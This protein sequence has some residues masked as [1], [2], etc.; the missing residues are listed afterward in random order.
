M[1]VV[2]TARLS[3]PGAA[4]GPPQILHS[5]LPPLVLVSPAA[6]DQAAIRQAFG[7]RLHAARERRGVALEDI[8]RRMKVSTAL[9]AALERGD[10]SRW[11]KGL[12]RRAF[13]RDYVAAIGLPAEPHISQFLQLFPDG[14]DHPIAG[15]VPGPGP[16]LDAAPALRLGLAPRRAWRVSA[17]DVRREMVTAAAV[18]FLALALTIWMGGTPLTAL[19]LVGL[20]YYAR[21]T[22]FLTARAAS[23][24]R[25][26]SSTDK[27]P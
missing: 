27:A 7:R 6:G 20:C 17:A 3:T 10:A 21:A 16:D 1:Q 9:L 2:E 4:T 22:A 14:E 19:G 25:R 5:E 13:F 24:W 11:P 8:A 26:R 12:F 15:A 23:L 18:L